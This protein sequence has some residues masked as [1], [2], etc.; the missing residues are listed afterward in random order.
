MT[1]QEIRIAQRFQVLVCE[2]VEPVL[3]RIFGSR[4]R[5]DAESDSDLDIL[6]VLESVDWE[7][8]KFVSD[9]AWEAGFY[10]GMFVSPTVYSFENFIYETHSSFLRSVK[11]EGIPL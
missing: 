3:M 7:T 10:E 9:C 11:R 6:V 2:R 5:G 1:E 8:Q 4:A